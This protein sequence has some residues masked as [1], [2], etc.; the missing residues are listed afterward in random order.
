[1][2]L[3]YDD[4]TPI[5]MSDLMTQKTSLKMNLIGRVPVRG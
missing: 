2:T 5:L 1:M 3:I 4:F